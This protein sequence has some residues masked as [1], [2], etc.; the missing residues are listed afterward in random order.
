MYNQYIQFPFIRVKDDQKTLLWDLNVL[1]S[2]YPSDRKVYIAAIGY[3]R[4][5]TNYI[6]FRGENTDESDHIKL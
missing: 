1:G 5:C 2:L 6:G 4:H 3:N